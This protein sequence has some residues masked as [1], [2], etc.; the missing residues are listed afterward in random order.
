M[1]LFGYLSVADFF[2]SHDNLLYSHNFVVAMRWIF[3]S[4]IQRLV[5]GFDVLDKDKFILFPAEA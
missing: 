3:T 2:Y 4:V 5:I 1:L